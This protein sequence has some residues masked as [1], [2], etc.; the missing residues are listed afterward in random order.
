M[1]ITNTIMAATGLP[2]YKQLRVS[3]LM[4]CYLIKFDVNILI[5]ITGMTSV[6]HFAF[7][8]IHKGRL[9]SGVRGDMPKSDKLGQGDGGL[10]KTDVLFN[11]TLLPQVF[12][13]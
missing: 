6:N 1:R 7:K 5:T 2:G 11:N 12:R 10:A 9:R 8:G 3:P 4:V 13:F